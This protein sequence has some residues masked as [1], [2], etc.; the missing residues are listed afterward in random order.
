MKYDLLFKSV[1]SALLLLAPTACAP[2]PAGDASVPSVTAAAVPPT[3]APTLSPEPSS[4]ATAAPATAT[5]EDTLL[6]AFVENGDLKLWHAV[7]NQTET[8][9]DGGGVNRVAISDDRQII[10]FTR[11]WF[12]FDQCEQTALWAI[13]RDGKNPREIVSPEELRATLGDTDCEYPSVV[14][15]QIEWL[16]RTHRL[17]Y[18]VISDGEHASPQGLYLADVDTLS[19]TD[20]IPT[21]Y[22][23]R[24]VSSP[25]GS[26][27]ALLSATSLGFINADGWRQDVL[28]Y[29]KKGVP[30]PLIPNGVWTQDGRA[31]LIAAP[32]ESE[33]MFALNYTIMRVPLDGSAA[34]E[35]VSV[36]NSHSDSVAFSPDGQHTAFAQDVDWSIA[37]LPVEVG[38]LAIPPRI[39]LDS[40]ANLHWSPAGAAYLF[41]DKSNGFLFQL[42]PDATQSSQVCG[43]PVIQAND[44]IDVIQ[45]IDGDQFLFLTR[46]PRSLFLGGLNGT[47]VPIVTWPSVEWVSPESFSAVMLMPQ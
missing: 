26:Q 27:I 45:W 6:V 29:P 43:E 4:Q 44:Y 10:A 33:S 3:V 25:D 40:Y 32:A 9:F 38:P 20:L 21:D 2:V 39:I 34:Q 13:D 17:V 23:L 28:T 37:P 12:D 14:F 47:T 7:T 5:V 16:P 46:E 36:T 24:F 42:C 22:S 11:R 19:I 1:L 41:P 31:F 35:L 30:I 15:S 8:I 18:S